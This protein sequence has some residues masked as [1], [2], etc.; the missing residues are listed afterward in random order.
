MT[1]HIRC[2]RNVKRF[3]TVCEYDCAIIGQSKG[4]IFTNF[5]LK[6]ETKEAVIALSLSGIIIVSF[7][8]LV[9]HLS[10]V[11]GLFSSAIGVLM[12][13]IYGIFISF[14]LMPLRDIVEKKWLKNVKWSD[15]A[16]H[17]AAVVVCMVFLVLVIVAFFSIL[18]PQLS[19]S[20]QNFIRN[21]GSYLRNAQQLLSNLSGYYPE[22]T[23]RLM[24]LLTDF[25]DFLTKQLTSLDGA[26]GGIVVTIGNVVSG[27]INFL[28]GIIITVYLLIDSERF[29]LQLKKVMFAIFPTKYGN[30]LVHISNL[31]TDMFYKFFFGKAMDSLIIGILCY[32]CCTIMKMP[33]AVMIAVIVGITNIIPVFGPFLGAIPCFIILVMID[34]VKALEFLV[35]IVILQQVDG[36]IIG[37]YILGD[38][39]GLPTLWVMFAIIVSGAMFGIVGMF[40]G[41]PVFAV[42]YALVREWTHNRLEEK[43]IIF[44][45]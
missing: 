37:P 18:I 16:K 45:E 32:I 3:L 42:I 20:I 4:V 8:L 12:P 41:V 5:H 17:N 14:L 33:Y 19:S 21:I 43:K 24:E 38:A 23:T 28:I 26:V 31:A 11:S 35:F 34:W 22:M 1:L 29:K 27:V 2:P 30:H 36:N 6:P 9:S 15:K 10:V 44:T 25:S 40:L 7:Y 13:F 39:V